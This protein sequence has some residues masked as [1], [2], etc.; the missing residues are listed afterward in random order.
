MPPDLS[1][2]LLEVHA[3]RIYPIFPE[4]RPALE[5]PALVEP[6]RLDLIDPSLQAQNAEPL[7]AS[8]V[9]QVIQ[10]GLPQAAPAIGRADV[11]PLDLAVV[12]R[13]HLQTAAGGGLACVTQDEEGDAFAQ[14]LLDRKSVATLGRI[15]QLA[16]VAVQLGEER[17]GGGGIWALGGDRD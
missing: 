16:Q 8:V 2:G 1:D 10:N 3:E 15:R 14:E 6:D 13:E 7:G 9:C 11:H 17:D 12:V 5:S 4:R